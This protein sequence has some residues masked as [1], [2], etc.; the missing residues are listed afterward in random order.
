MKKLPT[1]VRG[2][3]R[4]WYGDVDIIYP[5]RTVEQQRVK[6]KT[7]NCPPLPYREWIKY[8]KHASDEEITNKYNWLC[9]VGRIND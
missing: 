7:L 3:P 8:I 2:I 9:A 4:N 6:L 5:K 1:D